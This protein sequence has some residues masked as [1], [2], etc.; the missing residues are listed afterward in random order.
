MSS[1]FSRLSNISSL[2]QL[3]S[4]W[5]S[6]VQLEANFASLLS[7]RRARM[8]AASR[9]KVEFLGRRRCVGLLHASPIAGSPWDGG[10]WGILDSRSEASSGLR[11]ICADAACLRESGSLRDMNLYEGKFLEDYINVF[12]RREK[13]TLVVLSAWSA[14]D[15]ACD[16]LVDCQLSILCF[17]IPGC[18]NN[19]Q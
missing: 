7:C 12:T 11:D 1:T 9:R 6:L 18:C 8:V 15:H 2:V 10:S 14:N 13:V 3:D 19:K 4:A 16:P 17:G 5:F